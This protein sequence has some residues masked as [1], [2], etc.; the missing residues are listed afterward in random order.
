MQAP[1]SKYSVSDPECD[2]FDSKGV[3]DARMVGACEGFCSR[4]LEG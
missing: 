4:S 3:L 2:I 1:V